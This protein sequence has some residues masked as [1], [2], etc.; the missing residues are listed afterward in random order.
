[1]KIIAKLLIAAAALT[2][3][4]SASAV[5]LTGEFSGIITNNSGYGLARD[6]AVGETLT[7]TIYI[8]TEAA[9]LNDDCSQAQYTC[10]R[11]T[12]YNDSWIN[13]SYSFLGNTY[14]P[15]NSNYTRSYDGIFAYDEYTSDN[16]DF[17]Q[18]LENKY[19]DTN[20]SYNYDYAYLYILDWV[21]DIVT[22]E[23]LNDVSTLSVDWQDS[24]PGNCD[25]NSGE[26]GFFYSYDYDQNGVQQQ[27][28]ANLTSLTLNA[29]SV[30]EP[31]TFALFGTGLLGLAL[32]RRRMKK[33]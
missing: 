27:L 3:W 22:G 26:C 32:S 17:L 7:G 28:G 19:E 33:A 1:M 23:N 16:R 13:I 5:I 14:S 31:T 20:S 15:D 9:Q 18:I 30:P 6:S 24:T 12:D 4:Q 21:N 11:D 2:T 25:G 8:D 10:A 29:S